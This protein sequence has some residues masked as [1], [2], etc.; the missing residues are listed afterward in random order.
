MALLERLGLHRPELRAWASYDWGISAFQVAIT[1]A[2]FPIYFPKV[3]AADLPPATATALL[4]LVN[5]AAMVVIA[6][7]SPIL[8]TLAD[9]R[10]SKKPMLATFLAIGVASTAGLWFAGRGDIWLASLLYGGAVVGATGSFV[11]YEALLTHVARADEID[12]V[13]TAGYAI[14][15]IGGGV[16]LVLQ[17]AAIQG[18]IPL[19]ISDKGVLTRLA[20]V[21]T[22]VWWGLFSIPLFRGVTEP[23][24]VP[25]TPT[26]ITP[27]AV[28]GRLVHT[29]KGLRSYPQ[30]LLMLTAFLVYNDGIQTIIKLAA[31]V[32]SEIGI[33]E[34]TLITA[35]V[36]VQF[37]GVPCAF[38]FG[39]L[40][41]KIGA[42]RATLLGVATYA[43][44]AVVG[45]NMQNGRDFLVLAGLVALVQGGTQA[46][47]RSLFAR[48]IPVA[49][50]GEFFGLYS[51]F[52]KFAGI[53][54]P[55]TFAVSVALTG[56][57]R[58]GVLALIGF[59]FVG[60][61]LLL[62]VDVAE[63]E[64]R[65]LQAVSIPG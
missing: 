61:L 46:L 37:V 42:K 16:L 50:S 1:T 10:A 62:R 11:F 20:F 5:S 30:A 59:F 36:M 57:S 17:L 27:R 51:V 15:Y 4:G 7:L 45:R 65:A 60:F 31:T 28:V 48:M 33:A 8:G 56:S 13:S 23:A 12:R 34:S 18:I 54:G 35:I 19:G 38:A 25:G 29:F 9:E 58:N 26:P 32:G 43:V 40:A 22:A 24:A 64:R 53:F 39:F 49:R 2:L 21:A 52:E 47:S 55:L 3:V 44:I 14:G 63:G 41:G 6:I